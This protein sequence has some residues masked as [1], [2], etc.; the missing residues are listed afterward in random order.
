MEISLA[1]IDKYVHALHSNAGELIREAEILISASC[2]ARAYALAHFAR[3]ELAKCLILHA[4]GVRILAGQQVD[5]RKLKKRLQCHRSKLAAETAENA[6]L[7][8]VNGLDSDGEAMLRSG[9][10][11]VSERNRLKNNSLYV[12]ISESGV[13]IPGQVI[14]EL[15]ARRTVALAQGR[16]AEQLKKHQRL[17][18]FKTRAPIDLPELTATSLDELLLLTRQLAPVIKNIL[19]DLEQDESSS[20]NSVKSHSPN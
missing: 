13:S 8:L 15:K 11:L 10:G 4:T 5:F 3:E 7:L 19:H 2:F 9:G 17:G 20:L 18:P 6:V 12:D 1:Q 14:S 16:L